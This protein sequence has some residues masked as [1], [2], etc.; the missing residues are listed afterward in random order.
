MP[1]GN[2][3][4]AHVQLAAKCL[5]MD[6]SRDV[7]AGH[8]I[9]RPARS[10]IKLQETL[11]A[12]SAGRD[13]PAVASPTAHTGYAYGYGRAHTGYAYGY[14]RAHTGYAHRTSNGRS[15]IQIQIQNILVAQAKRAQAMCKRRTGARAHARIARALGSPH[16]RRKFRRR[17]SV[18][19]A[20]PRPG[21]QHPSPRTSRR[22]LYP[23]S[24]SNATTGAA[25][26]GPGGARVGGTCS[27]GAPAAGAPAAAAAAFAAAG[28][29]AGVRARVPGAAALGIAYPHAAA[30]T[31]PAP[32]PDWPVAAVMGRPA[33]AW[34]YAIPNAAAWGYGFPNAAAGD[35]GPG[36]LPASAAS[37][38]RGDRSRIC[39]RRTRRAFA[40]AY[41][42]GR[43]H[44]RTQCRP[45][46]SPG[47]RLAR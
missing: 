35:A 42:N 38:R 45:R 17:S 7:I 15:Q 39:I 9:G 30:A 8:V 47:P 6:A 1:N 24:T 4:N 29:A 36:S 44:L 5:F 26:A 10:S 16:A 12:V 22:R 2:T 37:A 14:G 40:N 21:R 23:A 33:A 46:R 13:S 11:R 31:G 25:A 20:A 18:S 43:T 32:P 28:A 34:G 19:R 27:A 41:H 3:C